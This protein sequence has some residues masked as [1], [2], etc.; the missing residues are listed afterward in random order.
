[1]K[2]AAAAL[3][4]ALGVICL[5]A[6]N[7]Q[8]A[9]RIVLPNTNV[10]RCSSAGCSQI[11]PADVDQRAIFPK[12][13]ILD[14]DQGCIYGMTVLYDKSVPLGAIRAALDDRYKQ[15]Y[16]RNASS[17]GVDVWRV[18]PQKFIVQLTVADRKWAAAG[19]KQVIFLAFKGK[20]ACAP[21]PR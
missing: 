8:G 9:A 16:G 1:M 5:Q 6:A 18:E 21:A 10:L 3:I 15:W 19:A 13:V 11:W 4:L 14:T 17:S 2:K 20:A 12:Q 7:G